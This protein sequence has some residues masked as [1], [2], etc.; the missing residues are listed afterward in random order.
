[1]VIVMEFTKKSFGDR[2]K[3]TMY[4]LKNSFS[5]I[6]RDKDI[7]KP[8]IRMVIY[9]FVMLTLL[10]FS[11]LTFFTGKYVLVGVLVLLFTIF[12]LF[13]F[14][15]FY[16]VRQKA[17]QSWIV[18]NTVTGKDI[19]YRDSVVHTKTEKSKLRLIAFVDLLMGYASSQK[20]RKKGVMG[21]LINLFLAALQEV[22][23]LLSHYMNPAVVIEQKPLKE[24]I[25]T[26][27]SLRNNV[28]ATLVGV[29]GI[30]FVG[31]VVGSL[32]FP[33]YFVIIALSLGAGYLLG[34]TMQTTVFSFGGFSFSWIPIVIGVYLMLMIGTLIRKLVD[35]TKVIYF[36]IFYTSIMRPN[37]IVKDLKQEL[38]NYLK[39]GG[40]NE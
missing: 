11:F 39:M 20:G 18:Y 31:K 10:L 12:I 19:S 16:Y 17:C 38:T 15:F 40:Q 37:E 23:D 36:T 26:I 9:S 22:W 32:L 35:S 34:M 25:P 29:F 28:P 21:V 33:V 3:D 4:L 6:G 14:S 2:F 8:V 30:D 1:M 27:K 7:L 24:I 13:P 5:V